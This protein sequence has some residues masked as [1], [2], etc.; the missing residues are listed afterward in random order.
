MRR[1]LAL[2]IG[3]LLAFWVGMKLGEI[4]GYMFASYGM[5][6]MRHDRMMDWNNR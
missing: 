3:V 1:W 2:V 4:K 5:V 6:P